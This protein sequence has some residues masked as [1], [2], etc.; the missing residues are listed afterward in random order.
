MVSPIYHPYHSGDKWTIKFHLSWYLQKSYR[1]S[2]RE[3]GHY[4]P[5]VAKIV[6]AMSGAKGDTDN[7]SEHVFVS[8]WV[9]LCSELMSCLPTNLGSW[10][11]RPKALLL[12]AFVRIR[13][14]SSCDL[15]SGDQRPAWYLTVASWFQYRFMT[16]KTRSNCIMRIT[17]S[18][19][20]C[21][22]EIAARQHVAGSSSEYCQLTGKDTLR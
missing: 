7:E 19:A 18:L 6:G 8:A 13:P 21:R 3:I 4:T 17:F 16:N 15:L 5:S 2:S 12:L 1:V 10:A 20:H 22:G 14:F 9:C 11:R